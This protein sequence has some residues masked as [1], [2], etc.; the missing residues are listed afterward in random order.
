[1]RPTA[2]G[3]ITTLREQDS[4][5]EWKVSLS[6]SVA[7]A[8]DTID[9]VIKGTPDPSFFFYKYD[10]ND[11]ETLSRTLLVLKQKGGLKQEPLSPANL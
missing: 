3:A 8:G 9:V 1:M 4:K 2:E 7:K 10:P 6:K 5:S 11:P